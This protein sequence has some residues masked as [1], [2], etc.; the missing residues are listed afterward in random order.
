MSYDDDDEF[1]YSQDW[2]AEWT[3]LL[4]LLDDLAPCLA[5]LGA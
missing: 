1:N 3:V 2:I 5:D 4:E